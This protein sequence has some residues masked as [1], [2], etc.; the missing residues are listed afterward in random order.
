MAKATP[1][2]DN[3]IDVESTAMTTDV[4]IEVDET[5]K[6]GPPSD[7]VP[8]VLPSRR[9]FSVFLG[10]LLGGILAAAIGFYAARYVV[11]EG[12]PFPGVTPE[13]NPISI[14]QVAQAERIT[15]L[16]A[17]ILEYNEALLNLMLDTS[18]QTFAET[19][20]TD[21]ATTKA[22]LTALTALLLALDTRLTEVE[23][24]PQGAGNEAAEIA[25][26]AYER[27]LA[28]IREMLAGE[29]QRIEAAGLDARA[30]EQD[31]EAI[32]KRAAVQAALSKLQGALN[33]G[34]P[35]TDTLT[36]IST[37]S[38]VAIPDALTAAAKNGVPTLP[39][40]Q[41]NFPAAARAALDASIVAGIDDGS[42]SRFTG[43]LQRQLGT[44]SLEPQLGDSPDAILSRAEA[45]L[46]TGQISLALQEISTLPNAGRAEMAGW[47]TQAQLR[48][49]V[50]M[51]MAALNTPVN[52]E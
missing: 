16:E 14:E 43:F 29:L 31:A 1:D 39:I 9:G 19:T 20:A 48:L 24:I 8:K 2:I 38:G 27:E 22:E 23:K 7:N 5:E 50:M 18:T 21:L 28:I 15:V 17:K 44:R 33:S 25:A 40:L 37:A 51:A 46:K 10:L 42:I 13:P 3:E 45:A 4:I 47:N 52:G 32:A 6:A 49:D 26:A 34:L 30:S 11:P 12:W 36:E 35:F 41:A